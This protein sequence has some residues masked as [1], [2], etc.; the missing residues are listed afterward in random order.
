VD[1]EAKRAIGH[2][3]ALIQEKTLVSYSGEI[4]RQGDVRRMMRHL[5]RYRGWLD[6]LLT[7]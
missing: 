2:L 6:R 5:S 4:Y 1:A 7:D 3:R